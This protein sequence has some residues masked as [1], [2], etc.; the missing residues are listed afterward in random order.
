M[1]KHK[2]AKPPIYGRSD[3]LDERS[4]GLGWMEWHSDPA[5]RLRPLAELLPGTPVALSQVVERMTEKDLARRCAS[6]EETLKIVKGLAT[7]TQVTQQ[8]RIPVQ[9]GGQAA[10]CAL[11]TFGPV[12]VAII[13]ALT[14]GGLIELAVLA[15]RLFR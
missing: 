10:P 7:R 1:G 2:M 5:R 15:A 12:Q 6:L 11:R 4:T 14:F 8:L 9:K 3:S 13:A